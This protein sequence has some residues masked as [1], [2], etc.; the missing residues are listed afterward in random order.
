MDLKKKLTWIGILYFAEGFPFGIAYDVWPVYFRNHGVSL[1]E[2]GLMALLFLPYTL[3]PGW[4]PLVDRLGSRQIWIAGA[5][6]LL[7][8]ASLFFLVIDPTN[9][10]WQLWALLLIFTTIS[11]TQDISI[12]AYAVDVSTPKDSGHINGLR[13]ALY[14][15]ALLFA[16][17]LLLL[18]SDVPAVGWRGVWIITSLVCF[19]LAVLAWRS[20]RAP[21]MRAKKD[22]NDPGLTASGSH[23]LLQIRLVLT[24]L[25]CALGYH[26]WS[27]GGKRLFVTLAVILA[28]MALA[29]FL[30]PELLRW[31]F[32]WQMVPVLGVILLYKLG[33][34]MLGR[35]VKPFWVDQGY[36]NW[37]IGLVSGGVGM[38]L[39]ILGALIGGWFVSR[40]GIFKS[41]LVMGLAQLVSN[42]GYVAVATFELPRQSIYAASVVESITQGLGTAA[43]LSFLM[44]LCDKEHSA[45]QYALLSAA[46]SLT[47]DVLGAF[48]GIGVEQLGYSNYFLLT[49]LL[50]LPAL[51]LLPFVRK[52][53]REGD[54]EV[55]GAPA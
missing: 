22:P 8:I 50:A 12:D 39:T 41:L 13:V 10:G 23:R 19:V 29:S 36:E 7:G 11:A 44:N 54:P 38:G 32:R 5:Q 1:R 27:T 30:S 55:E 26:A 43:F 9:T 42:F 17:S 28:A 45:T 3:K 15:A 6:F 51:L 24:V 18:L 2:I 21:R 48:S 4:A 25:A 34:N 46:F 16:G 47:R 49:S 52:Q 31:V 40:W 53:I 35:M 33:D 20:P 14:R 37:E